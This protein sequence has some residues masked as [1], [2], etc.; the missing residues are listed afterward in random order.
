M[1]NLR[2]TIPEMLSLIG[3]F[4]CVYIAIYILFRVNRIS[5]ALVPLLFF[6]VLGIAFFTDFARNYI[7]GISDYYDVVSWAA[8]Y[9]GPPIS[10]LVI[11]QVANISKLPSVIEWSVL[12][13]IPIAFISAIIAT[14]AT[15]QCDFFLECQTFM[16]WLNI[17]GLIAGAVSLLMIWSHKNIFLDILKQKAG[18]ERYWLILSLIVLNIFF[19]AVM[20]L[21]LGG[22]GNLPNIGDMVVMRTIIGLSFIY[23]VTTSLFRIYPQ[24]L[25]L[26]NTANR[27]EDLSDEDMA[28][29]KRIEDLLYLEKV[30]H[31]NTYSRSDMA[32]ELGVSEAAISR[33]ISV[34]FGKSFPQLLNERRIEDAKRLLL[35]TKASIRVVAQEVG[36]NSLPSFNRVFKDLSG[37]SPS[38][39]RKNMIK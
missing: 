21:R 2:F 32:R 1:D 29:A 9:Y 34:Y 3:V 33:V 36:F 26:S 31:E 13:F 19:L 38:E 20:T 23:L 8:W 17:S 24:A 4:Q 39:Y 11:I 18:K 10:V 7:G 22:G 35:E 25:V 6:V 27:E 12:L 15:D 28:L 16:E 5:Q 30:Y 37:T 14:K